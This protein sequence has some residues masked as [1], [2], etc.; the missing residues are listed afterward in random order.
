MCFLTVQLDPNFQLGVMCAND[1]RRPFVSVTFAIE[2]TVEPIGISFVYS[3]AVKY[4]SGADSSHGGTA[5][6]KHLP[7]FPLIWKDT[8]LNLQFILRKILILILCNYSSGNNYNIH[9]I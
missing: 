9:H 3:L 8:V 5:L 6:G 4:C 7:A 1:E 2:S